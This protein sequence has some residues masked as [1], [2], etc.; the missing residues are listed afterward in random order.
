M[1]VGG[2]ITD[3]DAWE[4]LAAKWPRLLRKYE[5][6][7]F[8]MS[9]IGNLTSGWRK[10][11]RQL[12]MA[13][14]VRAVLHLRGQIVVAGTELEGFRKIRSEFG[15]SKWDPMVACLE[16]ALQMCHTYA[17]SQDEV[18]GV[19]LD[20]LK[21][22]SAGRVG[23]LMSLYRGV[24]DFGDRFKS[25]RHQSRLECELLQAADLAACASF[26]HLR[27]FLMF[28]DNV[29]NQELN[30]LYAL[31]YRKPKMIYM[32]EESLRKVA[33]GQK[34]K[35]EKRRMFSILACEAEEND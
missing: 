17:K 12:M 24:P 28:G 34:D 8:H 15:W 22:G 27:K 2:I 10:K 11:K 21:P 32:D 30:A 6:P 26:R 33:P 14:F 5:L 25:W 1:V 13:D 7:E 31:S 3:F 35:T 29:A 9:K 4:T 16:H 19:L 18:F 23:R 20:Q